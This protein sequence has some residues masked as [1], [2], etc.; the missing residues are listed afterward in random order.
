MVESEDPWV[1]DTKRLETLVDGIFAIAM[2]I[3]VLD[4][5]VPQLTGSIS[6]QAVEQVLYTIL[7]NLKSM[8][9]SF[10]LLALFWTIHHRIFKQIKY[11][12]TTIL[13]I[14][15]IWLLFIVLV[16]FSTS[17]VG[18]YGSYPISH[19]IFNLN[20]LGV[21]VLLYINWHF[22]DRS[23]LIHEKVDSSQI[24]ITKKV[25]ALF[26]CISLL[27]LFLSYI[28]PH[29]AEIVYLLIFPL[30]PLIRRYA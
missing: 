30:E 18:D 25:N 28:V 21:A 27:A 5:A 13:W 19:A 6:N 17:I 23:D 22:A 24:A 29:W 8:V 4:L 20:L 14:N 11:L 9:L 3:L 10:I 7:P 16:P 15:L 1:L 26:I 12:N 2:T